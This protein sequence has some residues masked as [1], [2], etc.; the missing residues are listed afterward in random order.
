[1]IT[2]ELKDVW[3]GSVKTII[4]ALLAATAA[5]LTALRPVQA[6]VVISPGDILVTDL[7]KPG[8]CNVDGGGAV[9]KVNPVTGDVVVVTCGGV[10]G[11]GFDVGGVSELAYD[12]SRNLIYIA[13]DNPLCLVKTWSSRLVA[14]WS[15]TGVGDY[16]RALVHAMLGG[17]EKAR[18][19]TDRLLKLMPDVTLWRGFSTRITC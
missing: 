1:M 16:W 17:S 3:Q 19:V 10:I 2:M 9:F 7:S 15:R 5:C 6:A 8:D 12:E 4:Y 13:V 18:A 11:L 14:R